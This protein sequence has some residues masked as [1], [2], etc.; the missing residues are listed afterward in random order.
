M[1]DLDLLDLFS[2]YYEAAESHIIKGEHFSCIF[3]A[4]T[5]R[6]ALINNAQLEERMNAMRAI[7]DEIEDRNLEVL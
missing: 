5:G 1:Q 6:A 3:S 2:V 7:F 4:E